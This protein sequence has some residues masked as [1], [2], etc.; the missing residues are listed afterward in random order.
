M[1]V[2]V[3]ML[4]C[5]HRT[6]G[7]TARAAIELVR[8]L[9]AL[10]EGASGELDLVGVGPWGIG[11]WGRPPTEGWAPPLEV[12]RLPAPQQ[13]LY[14]TWHRWRF[15]PVQLATGRVDLVHAT[16]I[17]VPPRRAGVPLAVTVHDL[18]PLELPDQFTPRGLAMMRRG[19][20]LARERADVVL[21]SSRSTLDRCVEAGFDPPRLHHVPLGV[22]ASEVSPESVAEVRRRRRL[23]DRPYVLWV[24]T[25]EPRKNL[26]TLVRAFERVPAGSA[27]LVLVGP[28]G[29]HVDLQQLVSPLGNRV[30]V[31]GHVA[32]ADLAALNA[33]AA[34]AALPSHAEGFGLT[35]LEAM[36]QG[37]PVVVSA[38]SASEEVVGDA[39][40]VLPATDVPAWAEAIEELLSDEVRRRQLG[41]AGRERA[42]GYTWRRCAEATHAAYRA[43][44][45]A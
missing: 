31:L 22:S 45:P 39:G 5:W 24:G 6:P 8:A 35:A 3:T 12:R 23:A 1:R 2:G 21:C 20:D 29:W 30:R 38:G 7:G 14:E 42:A 9:R 41:H 17:T 27:D 16:T 13:V 4:Q 33:G 10:P 43:A 18:F 25:V 37:T 19:I 34:V 11:R 26:E 32:D 28:A 15:P 36:V 44:L 40:V